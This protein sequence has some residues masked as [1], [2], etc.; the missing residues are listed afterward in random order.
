MFSDLI[1]GALGIKDKLLMG[2]AAVLLIALAGGAA[3]HYIEVGI[4]HKTIKDQGESIAT[5]TVENVTLSAANLQLSTSL[6]T[7]TKAVAG[8]KSEAESRK[9]IAEANI[10]AAK[11]E[12][13]KWR[14]K[15]KGVLDAPAA[16]PADECKSL[17]LRFDQYLDL[18]SAP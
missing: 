16:I 11:A 18:R 2:V 6:Q 15:Y 8:L 17:N 14:K 5:L 4:L 9:R 10:E 7:Q 3:Y 1:S 13:D 12:G